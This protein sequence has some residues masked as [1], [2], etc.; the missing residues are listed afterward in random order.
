MTCRFG[1]SND[2][3]ILSRGNGGVSLR[4]DILVILRRQSM[5]AEEGR[6]T[7]GLSVVI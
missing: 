1:T 5:V 7:T 2:V 4:Q 3:P 6:V